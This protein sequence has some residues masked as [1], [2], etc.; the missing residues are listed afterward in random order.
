MVLRTE[1]PPVVTTED[2]DLTGYVGFANLP[3]QVFRKS[4]KRGFEFSLMVVGAS[5]LG[6]STLINS[7]FLS[8]IYED[9]KYPEGGCR[10]P[11]TVK[12]ASSTTYLIEG[13]VSLKLTLVDTPGFGDAIDNTKCWKPI[14]E[15]IDSKYEEYLI[16]E[17]HINRSTVPDHRI[18]CCLYFISPGHGLKP[19][20]I[21]FMKQLHEKVNIVPVIGKADTLTPEETAEFKAT[22]ME[23]IK[24]NDI[25]I[26]QFP[27]VDEEDEEEDT[28][29]LQAQLPFAVVGSNTMLD[30]NG[31]KM[32]GRMY[33]WGI[34]EVENPDHCD[35]ISL[36]NL[37]IRTHMQDLKDVTNNTLYENYRCDKLAAVTS[38]SIDS[39]L[40]ASNRNPL[41]QFEAEKKEHQDRMRTMKVGMEKVMEEKV[42]EKI[43]KMDEQRAD[44]V[45]KHEQALKHLEKQR[46]DLETK[47]KELA[48][49]LKQ[50]EELHLASG[51][52]I[53]NSSSSLN[54]GM[55][56]KSNSK[57]NKKSTKLF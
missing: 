41:A 39:K 13:G 14:L 38:V 20:D 35:F 16:A 12:V 32:R 50:L 2:K 54:S 43:E 46:K 11:Q 40:A 25:K 47:K 31:K 45:R 3:N 22:V 7:L 8:S 30:I 6:K 18:H 53:S 56:D 26:Y 49:S 1:T 15:H 44:L 27:M 23:E 10:L 52:P 55:K 57:K 19:L 5:G 9:D 37:L 36:R 51:V 4:V 17:G 28:Q 48:D 24:K 34:A 33:P 29:D 21:E 42:A